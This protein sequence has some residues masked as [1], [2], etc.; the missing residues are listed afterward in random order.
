LVLTHLVVKVLRLEDSEVTFSVF[1]SICHLL[2]PVNRSKVEAI[3]LCALP[4]STTSKIAGLS[5][6]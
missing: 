3:P 6:H 4:K 5:P 2:L 1:E